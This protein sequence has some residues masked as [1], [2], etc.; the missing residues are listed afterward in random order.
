M[1]SR[2]ALAE[3]LVAGNGGKESKLWVKKCSVENSHGYHIEVYNFDNKN[4]LYRFQ[5]EYSYETYLANIFR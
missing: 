5:I 4:T 3:T 1:R 2:I